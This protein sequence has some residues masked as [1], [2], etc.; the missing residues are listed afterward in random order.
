MD[1]LASRVMSAQLP[2]T[3]LEYLYRSTNMVTKMAQG[4][5]LIG[6]KI[7]RAVELQASQILQTGILIYGRKPEITPPLRPEPEAPISKQRL[8]GPLGPFCY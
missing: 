4:F 8:S 6:D 2:H 1:Y 5:V 7:S 3:F